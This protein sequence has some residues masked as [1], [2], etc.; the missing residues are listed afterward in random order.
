MFDTSLRLRKDT[1]LNSSNGSERSNVYRFDLAAGKQMTERMYL[2]AK[3]VGQNQR[4]K[5]AMKA[6]SDKSKDT[7]YNSSYVR[8]SLLSTT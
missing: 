6:G 3:V 1:D 2:N 7:F 4:N 5:E 8:H